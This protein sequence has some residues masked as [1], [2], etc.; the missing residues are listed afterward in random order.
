MHGPDHPADVVD[1][2]AL[3]QLRM[4]PHGEPTTER[5]TASSPARTEG[6]MTVRWGASRPNEEL[7]TSA[8]MHRP[9]QMRRETCTKV[10]V[11]ATNA[12]VVHTAGSNL[13]QPDSPIDLAG[14]LSCVQPQVLLPRHLER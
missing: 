13:Q 14:R 5:E 3:R 8:V 1:L 2:S 7:G 11:L 12:L 9:P 6:G 4:R 10:V